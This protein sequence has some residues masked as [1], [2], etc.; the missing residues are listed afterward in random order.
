MDM[1]WVA[2]W[3]FMVSSACTYPVWLLLM[4][5]GVYRPPGSDMIRQQLPFFTDSGL[6]GAV[7]AVPLVL[8]MYMAWPLVA[9]M[10]YGSGV[11]AFMEPH[12]TGI[13]DIAI[14]ACIG[15]G[16][17]LWAAFKYLP[18]IDEYFGVTKGF[19]VASSFYQYISI[20]YATVKIVKGGARALRKL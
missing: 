7:F 13:L 1:H 11:M 16:V 12:G 9:V 14:L 15:S 20:G 6:I 3:F 4:L 18:R 2:D 5:L 10:V 19:S 17:G 8:V